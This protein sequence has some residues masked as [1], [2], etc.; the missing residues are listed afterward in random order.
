MLQRDRKSG[1]WLSGIQTKNSR[2]ACSVL[3]LVI[4]PSCHSTRVY[5]NFYFALGSERTTGNQKWG[6]WDRNRWTASQHSNR[7]ARNSAQRKTAW[8]IGS[9]AGWGWILPRPDSRGGWTVCFFSL[10]WRVNVEAHVYVVQSFIEGR[11]LR[12]SR[13][14]RVGEFMAR[15]R[16]L[17]QRSTNRTEYAILDRAKWNERWRIFKSR[18][19]KWKPCKQGCKDE[20]QAGRGGFHNQT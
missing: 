9:T 13:E 14:N 17:L 12:S 2:K 11:S 1:S 3:F 19:R 7:T 18:L 10:L 6:A 16:Y 15:V 20:G 5:L 4:S 8:N